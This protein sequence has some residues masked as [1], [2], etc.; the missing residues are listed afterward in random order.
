MKIENDE[1]ADGAGNRKQ[2]VALP[3]L[4][5]NQMGWLI[6]GLMIDKHASE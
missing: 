3:F 1:E 4:Q 6:S 5:L 2:H